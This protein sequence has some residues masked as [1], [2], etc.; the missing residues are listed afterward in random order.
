[1][2]LSDSARTFASTG[3]QETGKGQKRKAQ[4]GKTVGAKKY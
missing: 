3:S 1:M 4:S 2:L